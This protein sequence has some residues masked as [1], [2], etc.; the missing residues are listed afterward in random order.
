MLPTTYD[1]KNPF[2]SNDVYEI[3]AN[4]ILA[5]VVDGYINSFVFERALYVYAATTLYSEL[6]E[7]IAKENQEGNI[8]NTWDYLLEQGTIESM[9]NEYGKYL[10]ELAENANNW[11][12]ENNQYNSSLK[13]LIDALYLLTGQLVDNTK[14]SFTNAVNQDSLQNVLQ[15]ADKWGMNNN[16]EQEQTPREYEQDSMFGK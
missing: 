4:S 3:I 6:I 8:L 5:S 1:D 7:E 9:Y 10:D 11:Y 12:N 16:I 15:V 2:S 13:S 14:D